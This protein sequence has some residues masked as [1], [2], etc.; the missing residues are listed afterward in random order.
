M[1]N[2]TSCL[3]DHNVIVGINSLWNIKNIREVSVVRTKRFLAAID[4]H[5]W[6]NYNFLLKLIVATHQQKK[7]WK[8]YISC[9]WNIRVRLPKLLLVCELTK[10]EKFSMLKHSILPLYYAKKSIKKELEALK[11]DLQNL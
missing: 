7:Y 10:K 3:T 11:L 4:W 8:E 9:L 5:I 1:N 6:K 2:A